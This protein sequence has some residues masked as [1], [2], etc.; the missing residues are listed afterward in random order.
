MAH[1]YIQL[2]KIPSLQLFKQN[3]KVIFASFL[4]LTFIL[5]ANIVGYT[6][7]CVLNLTIFQYLHY[8][9]FGSRYNASCLNYHKN[10][11][12]VSPLVL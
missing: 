9:Y 2:I 11:Q 6:S 10:L 12:L 3:S 1:N 7:K 4:Y 5:S 8:Y